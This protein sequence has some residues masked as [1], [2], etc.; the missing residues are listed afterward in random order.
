MVGVEVRDQH[1]VQLLDAGLLHRP[2]DALS[3]PARRLRPAGVDEHRLAGRGDGQRGPAALDVHPV[4][5]HRVRLDGT[6]RRDAERADRRADNH[7]DQ[8]SQSVNYR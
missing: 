3:V 8:V 1:V 5:V 6:R 4:D 7:A 2:D